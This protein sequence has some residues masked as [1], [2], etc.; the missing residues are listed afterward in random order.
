MSFSF[1]DLII[2]L[3]YHWNLEYIAENLCINRFDE[4]ELCYGKCFLNAAFQEKAD[5]GKMAPNKSKDFQPPIQ[6]IAL[7]HTLISKFDFTTVR[8]AK[9]SIINVYSFSYIHRVFHPPRMIFS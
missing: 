1:K 9:Q 6:Y 5:L 7:D 4:S 2:C 8:P 3:Q